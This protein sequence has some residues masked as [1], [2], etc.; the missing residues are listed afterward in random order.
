MKMHL[1]LSTSQCHLIPQKGAGEITPAPTQNCASADFSHLSLHSLSCRHGHCQPPAGD[2]TRVQH[3]STQLEAK[4][5]PM[6][7]KLSIKISGARESMLSH[8]RSRW[9]VGWQRTTVRQVRLFLL[10]LHCLRPARHL[11]G[12]TSN[13][14]THKAFLALHA[15]PI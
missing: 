14:Q 8:L 15:T 1:R 6:V 2:E 10:P 3:W 13:F 7:P 4:Q 12:A 5:P 9:W 11:L